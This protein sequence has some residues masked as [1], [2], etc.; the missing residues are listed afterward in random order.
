MR[1]CINIDKFSPLALSN[2]YHEIIIK[3]GTVMSNIAAYAFVKNDIT[4]YIL[5]TGTL[6]L[7]ANDS[8]F[9]RVEDIDDLESL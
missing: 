5:L 7:M 9:H 4:A 8:R 6:I 2:D 3:H 1:Y